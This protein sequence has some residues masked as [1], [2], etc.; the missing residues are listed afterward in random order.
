MDLDSLLLLNAAAYGSLAVALAVWRARRGAMPADTRAAF[1]L[2]ESALRHA[3]PD[4]P[5]GFTWREGL[6]MA[7]TKGLDI[8]WDEIDESLRRY[9]A[10]RYGQGPPLE[11]PRPEML[12]LVKALG[13]SL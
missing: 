13:G 5:E 7:K 12:K 6:G 1:G 11:P 4:L 9:E 2:L 3:F 8:R 10:Y